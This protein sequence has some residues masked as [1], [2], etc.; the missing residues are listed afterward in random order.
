MSLSDDHDYNSSGFPSPASSFTTLSEFHDEPLEKRHDT[1]FIRSVFF[2]AEGTFFC[3]PYYGKAGH[4]AEF[5]AVFKCSH[6]VSGSPGSS[7]EH[8]IV[9]DDDVTEF[10][11]AC[12][13]KAAHIPPGS[14]AHPM[15][16]D[17]WM[18]V[19]KLCKKYRLFT[20]Q[21]I[22][23]AE[24]D[25]GMVDKSP[26]EMVRLGRKYREARWLRDGYIGFAARGNV[27]TKDEKAQLDPATY[28]GLL[29]LRDRVWS[30]MV[31]NKRGLLLNWNYWK[32]QFD[33][34]SALLEIFGEEMKVTY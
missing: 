13:L 24:I 10:D 12:L 22:A 19:L 15:A 20:I 31:T 7:E 26:I 27:I 29:E 5:E 17:E 14:P 18:A 34:D 30:W 16:I 25:K 2:K 6:S 9:L 23:V 33:Y 3:I 8:P 28:V 32:N 1:F 11:F 4:A 21:S